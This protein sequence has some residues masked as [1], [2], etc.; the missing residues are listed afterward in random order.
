VL[1]NF[2]TKCHLFHPKVSFLFERKVTITVSY[3]NCLI[4]D[5]HL[6]FARGLERYI[7]DLNLAIECNIASDEPEALQ[8]LSQKEFDFIFVDIH[9]GGTNG[10]EVVKY[11]RE[12]NPDAYCVAMSGDKNAFLA[13]NMMLAGASN[14]ILKS[15]KSD[16]LYRTLD[17]IIN[18]RSQIPQWVFMPSSTPEDDLARLPP[19]LLQISKMIIKGGSNKEIANRLDIT[20]NTV[21]TQIKRLYEKMNV[22]KRSEFITKYSSALQNLG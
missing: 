4:V 22:S 2:T 13:R 20:E 19:K 1:L 17:D 21:K 6:L 12:K 10:L 16:E 5:D 7:N 9:L 3:Q 15:L 14:F 18:M 11:A 8:R